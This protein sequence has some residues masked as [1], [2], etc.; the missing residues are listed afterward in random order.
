M[1]KDDDA[2]RRKKRAEQLRAEIKRVSKGEGPS[3]PVSPREMTDK[4]AREKYLR[5]TNKTRKPE[6]K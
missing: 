5:D 2:S 3:R 4:A 1:P 6:N